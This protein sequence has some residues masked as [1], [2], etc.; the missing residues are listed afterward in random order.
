MGGW[1]YERLSV[2]IC[3]VGEREAP[4]RLTAAAAA[5]A[6]GKHLILRGAHSIHSFDSPK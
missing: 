5:D 4:L 3:V 1:Q 2:Y 6:D